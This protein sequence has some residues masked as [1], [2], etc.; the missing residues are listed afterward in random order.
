MTQKALSW[1]CPRKVE[2]GLAQSRCFGVVGQPLAPGAATG[3]TFRARLELHHAMY[4][5]SQTFVYFAKFNTQQLEL[6]T[7]KAE[8]SSRK[9]LPKER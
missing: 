3:A 2:A 7:A 4:L 8:A 5:F 6:F 1:S 9:L